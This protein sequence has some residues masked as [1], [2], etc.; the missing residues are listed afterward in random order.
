MN[1]SKTGIAREIGKLNLPKYSTVDNAADVYRNKIDYIQKTPSIDHPGRTSGSYIQLRSPDF[2]SSR[3]F[4]SDNADKVRI[5]EEGNRSRRASCW[6]STTARL[7]GRLMAFKGQETRS[8][9]RCIVEWVHMALFLCSS[10]RD[11]AMPSRLPCLTYY[12]LETS[13][14]S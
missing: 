12:R 7:R 8:A 9:P 1:Q 14:S 5:E 4:S 6:V 10:C 13:I 2:N 3:F 11:R